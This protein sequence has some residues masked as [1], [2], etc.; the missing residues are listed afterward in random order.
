[1]TLKSAHRE[2]VNLQ[3]RCRA[4]IMRKIRVAANLEKLKLPLPITDYLGEVID[5]TEPLRQVDN[6]D[7]LCDF[8]G[9]VAGAGQGL[10]VVWKTAYMYINSLSHYLYVL[11]VDD[12]EI[13]MMNYDLDV[14]DDP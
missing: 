11:Q 6:Y 13:R 10:I 1:M 2:F 9:N 8:Q 7:I 3:D 4:V 5:D 12:N 14:E